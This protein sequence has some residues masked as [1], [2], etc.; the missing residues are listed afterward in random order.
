MNRLARGLTVAMALR[1]AGCQSGLFGPGLNPPPGT[2]SAQPATSQPSAVPIAATPTPPSPG[3][4]S[5]LTIWL[6][7]QFNPNS[8][9]TAGELLKKRLHDFSVD[10]PTIQIDVRVKA[11]SGPGGLLESLAASSA[12][13]PA[14]LPD[15]IALSLSDMEAAGLKGLLTPL[16]GLTTA[17]DEKDWYPYARQMMGLQGN[18][19]G[20]PFAGDAL[21]LVYR[22]AAVP[23]PPTD[24]A[25]LSKLA[26]PVVFPAA[27][28][29][30]RLTLAL[31]QAAGG[32]IRDNQG[33]PALQPEILAK[34]LNLYRDGL[35][36]GTFPAGNALLDSDA[37]I[38]QAYRDQKDNLAFTWVSHYLAE[39]PPD[40]TLM[41]LPPA[42]KTTQTLATGWLWVF[43]SPMPE[44]RAITAR[45][46]EYMVQSDFLARWSV[47]AGYLP[48]RPS[49]LASW[50]DQSLA[51]LLNQVEVS[52]VAEPS[53]DI[54]G[55][56]GPVL[57]DATIQVVKSQ[58]DPDQT[59]QAAAQRIQAP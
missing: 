9:T 59:A 47:A 49:S 48:T 50:T 26:I 5:V 29:Q 21:V 24:W 30:G 54:L 51:S 11:E 53:S 18:T 2:P 38:W 34:V 25:T 7:P 52:A 40:T 4:P 32:Q 56:L 6:P 44:K 46:A 23:K 16:D 13:A 17:P 22:P 14:A 39:L 57:R 3:N 8:G 35:A 12:A 36:N 19:F 20:L 1:L 10:N 42:E 41:V 37:Q 55:S 27:D 15:M 43:S 58:G 28:E 45:L 31:Y 33:R